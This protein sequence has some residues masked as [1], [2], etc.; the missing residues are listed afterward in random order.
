MMI[1]WPA[2][3][4]VELVLH[5]GARWPAVAPPAVCPVD[6]DGRVAGIARPQLP[7]SPGSRDHPGPGRHAGGRQPGSPC[8]L[9][10]THEQ[11]QPRGGALGSV[12]AGPGP[13]PPRPKRRVLGVSQRN[14]ADASLKE[15]SAEF[16]DTGKAVAAFVMDRAEDAVLLAAQRLAASPVPDRRNAAAALERL[17]LGLRRQSAK[18][19]DRSGR[20]IAVWTY[21]PLR[22][23]SGGSGWRVKS[24]G[25]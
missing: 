15:L 25:G 16:G 17:A 14:L 11:P 12:P 1:E 6:H 20:G 23:G 4:A 19:P 7:S 22:L 5:S 10:P 8:V 3:Q 9:H 13:L 24:L 21:W 2:A 18:L